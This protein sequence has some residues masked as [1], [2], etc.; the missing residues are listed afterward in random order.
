MRHR[1]ILEST[2]EGNGKTENIDSDRSIGDHSDI[3][4]KHCLISTAY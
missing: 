1:M 2:S 4:H 3:G